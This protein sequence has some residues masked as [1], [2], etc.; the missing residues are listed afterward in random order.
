MKKGKTRRLNKTLH[1][2]TKDIQ[3]HIFADP[4]IFK[5]WSSLTPLAKNEWICWIISAKKQ[6]TRERRIRVGRDKL[7]RGIRRPCC[8]AGCPHR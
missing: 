4:K 5:I 1:K 3:G 8:F 2:I 6:E 7:L